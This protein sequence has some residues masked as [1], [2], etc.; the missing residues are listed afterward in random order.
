MKS[1]VDSDTASPYEVTELV[2]KQGQPKKESDRR[3]VHQ[4]PQGISS[5][6]AKRHKNRAK[7]D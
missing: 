7:G 6:A 5:H 1:S 4:V 2:V 3:M